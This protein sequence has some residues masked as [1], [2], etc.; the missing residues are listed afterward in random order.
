M[1][2]AVGTNNIDSAARYGYINAISAI[3]QV[4]GNKRFEASL[5]DIADAD[6]ILAIG[7]NI[8][9]VNPIAGLKVRAAAKRAQG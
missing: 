9:E 8:T 5:S 2:L 4:I 6:V 3:K 1:R 7:T